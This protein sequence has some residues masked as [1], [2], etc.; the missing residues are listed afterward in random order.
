MTSRR[1]DHGEDRRLL[2]RVCGAAL[3]LGL[4]TM[5]ATALTLRSVRSPNAVSTMIALEVPYWLLWAAF[6]P[7]VLR[8]ARSFPLGG[9]RRSLHVFAHA[10]IAAA[11]VVTHSAALLALQR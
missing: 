1:D 4:L 9:P 8:G 7:A 2:Q 11:L 10:G 3:F 6:A 5:S